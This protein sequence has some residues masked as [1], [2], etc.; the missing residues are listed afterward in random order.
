MQKFPFRFRTSV[1]V[2]IIIVGVLSALMFFYNL[3]R[4]FQI[5]LAF[6]LALDILFTV[7]S[8]LLLAADILL[9]LL[10]KYKLDKNTVVITLAFIPVA[11]IP[12]SSIAKFVIS[13]QTDEYFMAYQKD[14]TIK[15]HYLSLSPAHAR[16]LMDA[17]NAVY[18]DIL[19]EQI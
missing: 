19:R 3:Y 17:V 6:G 4:L 12:F 13:P 9:L 14:D 11:R 2:L 15:I 16:A 7:I 5:Q 10:S 18:P 1:S 8:G